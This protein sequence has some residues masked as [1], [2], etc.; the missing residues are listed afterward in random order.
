MPSKDEKLTVDSGA[1]PDRKGVPGARL[2]AR[3]MIL[4]LGLS[5]IVL[6]CIGV[7]FAI[8]ELR[9]RDLNEEQRTL[10]AIDLLLVQETEHTLQ[11]VD[12]VLVNVA[13]KLIADDL[14]TAKQ[15]A[16]K[17]SDRVTFEML[18]SRIIGI[19]QLDVVCLIGADGQVINSS[20][21]YPPTNFTVVDHD[22]FQVL[23]HTPSDQAFVSQPVRNHV[24]GR[25]TLYLARRVNNASGKFLGLVI[26]GID[27]AYFENL[28][29]TL[30]IGRGGTVS[31]WR[32]DGTLLARYPEHPG[33]GHIFKRAHLA[34]AD[35][36]IRPIAFEVDDSFDGPQR[37]I[38]TMAAK[39][40]PIVVN[41]SKAMGQVLTDWNEVAALMAAGS[42]LCI[43]ALGFVLWLLMRQ[44]NTYEALTQAHEERS[45]AIAEREQAEAQLRQAQKLETIGQLTGGIAHDFNNLLTAV[46][47]NLELLKKHTESSDERLH[48]WA[49]NAYDAANRGA[50]LTQRLLVFSRRQ[51]LDPRATD[52]VTLLASMSD[53]LRR[54]LGENIEVT[55]EIEPDLWPAYA[56]LNQLDNAILN[57]AINARDAMEGRGRL[58]IA[59][60]NTHIAG[61]RRAGDPE[62]EPGEYVMLAITDTGKGIP[63]DVLERVFEPFFSTKPIGQGTGLGLSQVYGFVKQTGG[64]VQIHSQP[65]KGARVELYLPRAPHDELAEP[66]PSKADDAVRDTGM[67]R[68]L[69]VED[70]PD[71]RAY[72]AEILRELGFVVREV[73]NAKLALDLLRTDTG[74][75]LLFSDIGLPGMTGPELMRE[76]LKLRPSLKI[77]LTTGYAQDSI[78]DHARPERGVLLIAKPFGRADLAKK[79]GTLFP[80][81]AQQCA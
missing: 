56:D 31:L 13:E 23:A 45:K 76:A 70:D 43:V 4:V 28:Y 55:T 37:L 1:T 17:E 32:A 64:H 42:F 80:P 59:A 51:P 24:T 75:D 40:F 16:A 11:S 19:P 22:Y 6:V 58:I 47:G 60:R 50:V 67:G 25:W 27:L 69:V 29:K 2:D 9:R 71:V 63:E 48:R 65:D 74:I 41:I 33:I 49:N 68:I 35:Q 73:P 7:A 44:A 66:A 14:T 3:A 26:G 18:K 54:T 12:L 36:S 62:I 53:L 30:Q 61:P 81:S 46:L 57:I 21:S 52:V 8:Y 38:A 15:F 77:L 10:T 79:I 72:S 34:R 78:I 5:I 20:R 39:Q